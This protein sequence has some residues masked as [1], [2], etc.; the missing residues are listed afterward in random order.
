MHLL[1][2]YIIHMYENMRLTDKLIE[3]DEDQLRK[4]AVI[5]MKVGASNNINVKNITTAPLKKK[6]NKKFL[7]NLVVSV[8][9]GFF[10][11]GWRIIK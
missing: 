5:S 3:K 2:F 4:E 8:S 7:N 9:K 10:N 1:N 6:E 11:L